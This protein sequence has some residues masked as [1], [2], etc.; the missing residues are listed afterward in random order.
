MRISLV[1]RQGEDDCARGINEMSAGV[2]GL[3]PVPC[4]ARRTGINLGQT[5]QAPHMYRRTKKGH[6]RV[7]VKLGLLALEI[8]QPSLRSNQLLPHIGSTGNSFLLSQGASIHVSLTTPTSYDS[9]TTSNP[10]LNFIPQTVI[11]LGDHHAP[12]LPLSPD[13]SQQVAYPVTFLR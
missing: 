2:T 1:G 12:A 11:N 4:T 3:V 9:C 8:G 7:V 13:S 10:F 5:W 6:G